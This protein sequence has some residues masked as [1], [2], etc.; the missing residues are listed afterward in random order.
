MGTPFLRIAAVVED[1]ASLKGNPGFVVNCTRGAWSSLSATWFDAPSDKLLTVGITGTNGKTTVQW[2]LSQALKILDTS[3][4]RIGTLGVYQ[5]DAFIKETL[6]TPDAYDIQE[7]LANGLANGVSAAVLE[8]SS[9]GLSQQRVADVA[10]DV[11]VFTNLT[12]DHLDYHETFKDYFAAKQE[13]LRITAAA[14][15]KGAVINLDDVETAEQNCALCRELELPFRTFGFNKK[16]EV[17]IKNVSLAL[18]GA[19][20]EIERAGSTYELKTPCIGEHNASNLAAVWGVLSFLEY[21]DEQIARVLQEVVPAPGRLE[22]VGTADVGVYVDYAHTPD[23]LENV[24]K[25]L[26]PVS[27]KQLW[28]IVGCGGDRDPGK[29]PI[30]GEIAG[31]YA[32]KVVVTSDNPRTEDPDAIIEDIL[33]AEISPFLVEADRKSAIMQTLEAA[34]PGDIVLVAG[35]GHED[36]QILGTEK[37]HFSDQEVVREFFAGR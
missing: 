1:E 23:A 15:G 29:R 22:S 18:D 32:D 5:D 26:R 34:K 25:A 8:V 6:T 13:L 37:I 33:K 19:T 28:V 9:H 35:K 17:R 27:S 4:V 30:M 36:Y 12:R 21:S 31:R 20:I 14:K 2:L 11:A 16:A 3:V 7:S 10:F 24:L